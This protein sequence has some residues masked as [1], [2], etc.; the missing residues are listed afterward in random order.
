MLWILMILILYRNIKSNLHNLP[1]YNPTSKWK[2]IKRCT[3]IWFFMKKWRVDCVLFKCVN[4]I[5]PVYDCLC[6]NYDNNFS[7]TLL[8]LHFSFIIIVC[9]LFCEL[10]SLWYLIDKVVAES[11]IYKRGNHEKYQNVCTYTIPSPPY[12]H[13]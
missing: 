10:I 11:L 3:L 4:S 9:K 5:L 6:L 8:L 12:R 2:K 13:T 7:E 1:K